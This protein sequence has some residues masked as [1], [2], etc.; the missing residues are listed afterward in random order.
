MGPRNLPW[1]S[2]AIAALVLAFAAWCGVVIAEVADLRARLEV[3]IG[4][5]VEA[6]ERQHALQAVE[7]TPKVI[8]ELEA[9]HRLIGETRAETAAISQQLGRR[10]SSINA[11][12]F[13]AIGV[14]GLCLWLL[15]VAHRRRRQAEAAEAAKARFI[16]T[17]SH[18]I[19]SPLSAVMG[20]VD[21]L[22][23][24]RLDRRQ[25][26]YLEIARGAGGSL[27]HLVNDVLDLGRAEAGALNLAREPFDLVATAEDVA[28]LFAA[29]AESKGVELSVEAAAGAPATVRGDA[30]RMRQVLVN[31]VGNAVKFTDAGAVRVVLESANEGPETLRVEV[32]DTGVGMRPDEADRVFE[33]YE[34]ASTGRAK[35]GTGLGLPIAKRLVE[36]MGG[37]IG[38]E[39]TLGEGSVFWFTAALDVV[40]GLPE[41]EG[42]AAPVAIAG[43]G[44]AFDA[45]RRQ[46][47][48]WGVPIE[49][50]ATQRFGEGGIR[51]VPF[52]ERPEV[53]LASAL[54]RPVRPS[55]LLRILAPVSLEPV[56][57]LVVDDSL[58]NR[59]V[60]QRMLE[61]LGAQADVA[62]DGREGLTMSRERRYEIVFCD[63]HMPELDGIG[64]TRALAAERDAAGRPLIV[65]LS[66]S[67]GGDEDDRAWR[68]AGLDMRLVKPASMADI[69]ATLDAA[70]ALRA[71]T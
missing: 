29:R 39:S 54:T 64:L 18:E 13:G 51:L 37:R 20:V 30:A 63:R 46:L 56:V 43:E 50:G 22:E 53:P 5:L 11:V 12:S 8:A 71:Q 61:A 44:P 59:R 33:A 67:P 52:S 38:V 62:V 15:V 32:H 55:A 68:E 24:S 31:L 60:T 9:T 40:A 27:L 34:R 69:R 4:V 48:A 26:E 35:E 25:R 1:W 42:D 14:A 57:A 41:P 70:R 6:Q 17:L 36:A 19:R 7:Q 2:L 49:E 10:W 21:L 66:G 45:L 3:R 16:S 28:M 23:R 58:V 47:E 65:A